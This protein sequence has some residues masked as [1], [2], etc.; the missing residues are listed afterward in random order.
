[1]NYRSLGRTG[2]QVSEVG[3]GAWGIGGVM[4]R[5]SRDDESLRALHAAIDEGV[6]FLDTALVYGNG[7]SEN[8]V[9]E[10]LRSRRDQVY[11]ATKVPPK[12]MFWPAYGRL[13]EVFPTAHIV[14]CAEDSLRNLGLDH[15]DLL[16]LHVWD[17]TWLREDSWFEALEALRNQGKI[18]FFGISVNDHQPETALEVVNSGKID[19]V[20][21]IYNIFDQSPADEL[22]TAC[23]TND[24]GVI[25]RVPFDEGSLTGKVKPDTVFPKG[26]WRSEYFKED[27]KEAVYQRVRQLEK[28][29]GE[30]SDSLPDLALRF[31]L[32]PSAVST[33]IPGMRSEKHVRANIASSRKPQL[34]PG[35]ISDLKG[36]RWI[37]NFYS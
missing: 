37:R 12:N 2:L 1:M 20:Q 35:L 32:F 21:V 15:L 34:S 36:F 13:E 14:R 33:V 9:G 22:F 17:P 26:D 19:T 16:Q 5:D 7:H 25:V 23:Q 28:L 6:N 18:R 31:T 30:E 10:V 29:L 3:F 4:W 8:L 27:R 11:V 24:V